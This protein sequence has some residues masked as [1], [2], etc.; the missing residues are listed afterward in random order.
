MVPTGSI[1]FIGVLTPEMASLA[2]FCLKQGCV[3]TGSDDHN[4]RLY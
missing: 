1:H 2:L 3:V 4:D